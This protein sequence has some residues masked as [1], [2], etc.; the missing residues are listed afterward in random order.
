MLVGSGSLISFIAITTLLSRYDGGFDFRKSTKER[1]VLYFFMSGILTWTLF[2]PCDFWLFGFGALFPWL[3]IQVSRVIRF[4]IPEVFIIPK[5]WKFLGPLI[6][7]AFCLGK[8]VYA[9]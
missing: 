4:P 7:A 2:Y 8:L 1:W 6:W 5:Y 3:F 9:K